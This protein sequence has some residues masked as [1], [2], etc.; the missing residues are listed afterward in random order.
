MSLT[1]EEVSRIMRQDHEDDAHRPDGFKGSFFGFGEHMLRDNTDALNLFSQEEIDAVRT[2]PYTEEELESVRSTAV[3]GI[4]MCA[5]CDK[6]PIHWHLVPR[7]RF[8][9]TTFGKEPYRLSHVESTPSPKQTEP[10][11]A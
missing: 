5:A 9:P 6:G 11:F 7:R 4:C 3:L 2:F 10:V 8:D 1:Y